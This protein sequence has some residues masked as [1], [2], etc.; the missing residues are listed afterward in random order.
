MLVSDGLLSRIREGTSSR[1][2][3]YTLIL[4]YYHHIGGGTVIIS[5]EE[6]LAHYGLPTSGQECARLG[7]YMST[8]LEIKSPKYW[9]RNADFVIIDRLWR[10]GRVCYLLCEPD[11]VLS[12]NYQ[13]KDKKST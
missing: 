11:T 1:M 2:D 3:K 6:L 12:K 5:P 9:L 8:K 7:R 10:N 13:K 4:D